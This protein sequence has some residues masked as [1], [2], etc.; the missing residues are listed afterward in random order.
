MIWIDIPFLCAFYG[1]SLTYTYNSLML[2]LNINVEKYVFT[3]NNIKISSS[4]IKT[5]DYRIYK[6][7]TYSTIARVIHKLILL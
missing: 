5:K 1:F 7:S 2:C 4:G 6:I 3:I